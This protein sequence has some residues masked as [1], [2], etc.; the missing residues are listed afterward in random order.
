MKGPPTPYFL[1]NSTTNCEMLILVTATSEILFVSNKV[2][3]YVSYIIID[4]SVVL[5]R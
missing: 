5:K 2:D 1:R 3:A 4:L